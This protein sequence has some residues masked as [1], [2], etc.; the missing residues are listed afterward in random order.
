MLIPKL[1]TQL[2]RPVRCIDRRVTWIENI[3]KTPLTDDDER[4]LRIACAESGNV[5]FGEYYYWYLQK[6]FVANALRR[7]NREKFL[8]LLTR[9]DRSDYSTIDALA[10]SKRGL[11]IA[12]PHHAHYILSII[13]LAERLRSRRKTFLFYGDPKTHPGNEV[14]DRLNGWFWDDENSVGFIHNTRTGLATAI[15][16]LRAGAAVFIMPDVFKDE[17]ST[18]PIRFCNRSLSI[19]LG[20]ATL[21]RK[22]DSLIV[23]MIS[24]P[25]ASGFG[26]KSI[27]APPCS[28][29]R[30]ASDCQSIRSLLA[31]DYRVMRGLFAFYEE[32][33]KSH[34]IYWQNVR[35]HIAQ[36]GPH[37]DVPRA[38]LARVA[39]LLER[40]PDMLAPASVMDLRN[41]V[42][43][44]PC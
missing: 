22:T 5:K 19:M 44:S 36:N 37:L 11:L 31:Y 16:E 8:S 23:P 32:H 7:G 3:I 42:K 10:C 34:L 18:F 29:Q 15:R 2:S 35:Q 41:N 4:H 26:F 14:F 13:M 27:F 1:M 30:P 6:L 39:G 40:D 9:S 25:T 38:E 33:I 20:T 24:T 21:S 12:I 43:T 28:E 17:N